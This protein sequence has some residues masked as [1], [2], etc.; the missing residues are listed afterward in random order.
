MVLQTDEKHAKTYYKHALQQPDHFTVKRH[1]VENKVGAIYKRQLHEMD[2]A[3]ESAKHH[4]L[5]H[6]KTVE[7]VQHAIMAVINEHPL[8]ER[9]E[10]KRLLRQRFIK[11]PTGKT[12]TTTTTTKAVRG[13]ALSATPCK[14]ATAN[15]P[16]WGGADEFAALICKVN[17]MKTD[18]ARWDPTF[19]GMKSANIDPCDQCGGPGQ[20]CHGAS[21]CSDY[22]TA[23]TTLTEEQK[24]LAAEQYNTVKTDDM[25]KNLGVGANHPCLMGVCPKVKGEE[26]RNEDCDTAV[27]NFCCDP[28]DEECPLETKSA[29]TAAGCNAATKIYEDM[30]HMYSSAMGDNEAMTE[31]ERQLEWLNMEKKQEEQF[32]ENCPFT[33]PVLCQDPAGTKQYHDNGQEK[34]AEELARDGDYGRHTQVNQPPYEG[35]GVG[36][37]ACAQTHSRTTCKGNNHDDEGNLLDCAK[38]GFLVH[39]YARQMNEVK[40]MSTKLNNPCHTGECFLGAIIESCTVSE[41]PPSVRKWPTEEMYQDMN[42]MGTPFGKL[43]KESCFADRETFSTVTAEDGATA[44]TTTD[45]AGTTDDNAIDGPTG[46]TTD[47]ST[48][49]D[50]RRFLAALSPSAAGPS[51]GESTCASGCCSVWSFFIDA[52]TEMSE[53]QGSDG[54]GPEKIIK[55]TDIPWSSSF[56]DP[57][58]VKVC[59]SNFQTMNDDMGGG[60]GGGEGSASGSHDMMRCM[61]DKCHGCFDQTY[62]GADDMALVLQSGKK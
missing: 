10:I 38:N 5:S 44:G 22:L 18:E 60:Y 37:S 19:D 47:G 34:T 56:L 29:C 11:Y 3:M 48:D 51:A 4:K 35:N 55:I 20:M 57:N 54:S 33:D 32:Q 17:F 52:F 30:N 24:V 21:S 25:E 9:K 59:E 16:Y 40:K 14:D 41:R 61:W 53:Q 1:S 15:Y 36:V 12:A 39:P 13:R 28:T 42:S 7:K 26:Q 2:K 43:S 27:S 45:A 62:E 6:T 58:A 31:E 50:R 23:C 46:G 8:H 49:G